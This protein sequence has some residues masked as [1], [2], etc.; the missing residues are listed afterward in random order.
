MTNLW[1]SFR[2]VTQT[3]PYEKNK[4]DPLISTS[5][6]KTF[7]QENLMPQ[8]DEETFPCARC[9]EVVT[10]FPFKDQYSRKFCSTLHRRQQL[11]EEAAVREAA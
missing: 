8:P 1:A 7:Q 3:L 5:D 11:E 2:V 10:K 6:T 4:S 9:Q